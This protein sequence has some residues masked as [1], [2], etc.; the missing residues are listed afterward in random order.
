MTKDEL[1]QK[2]GLK[3]EDL[4]KPLPKSTAWSQPFWDAAKQHKLVLKHCRDC[5]NIDHPPYL[6]CTNC[7][8]DNME[9]REASGKGVLYGF[10]VNE[11]AVPIPFMPDLPYV[12]A[13]IDLDEGVRMISNIVECDFKELKNGMR[14]EVVFE[15][16]TPEI[17]LPKWRPIRE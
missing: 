10:G 4:E 3:D 17:T 13:F 6:Y 5:G 14:V 16:I 8:S 2:M 9:W 12:N 15:D 7:Q 1:K 11:A